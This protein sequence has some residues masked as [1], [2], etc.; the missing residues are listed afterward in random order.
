MKILSLNLGHGS[1]ACLFDNENL[2]YF[3]QEERLN[4]HKNYSG[5]PQ[6]CLEE[7][8]KITTDIDLLVITDYN[9]DK[10]HCITAFNFVKNF[11]FNVQEWFAQ[12]FP[13]HLTHACKS[14][15]SSPFDESIVVVWDGRGS[16]FNLTDGSVAYETTSVFHMS[17]DTGIKLLHK[18]LWRS[19]KYKDNR[20]KL[21][22]AQFG[23]DVTYKIDKNFTY[24]IISG[25]HDIGHYYGCVAEHFGYRVLDCGK[26]MGLHSYGSPNIKLSKL[27]YSEK[28]FKSD[29]ISK[30]N[31][32]Q[33]DVDKYPFL[34]HEDISKDLA[35]EVQKGLEKVGL[36]FLKKIF[37][38]YHSNNLVL[39]G[40]VSLNIVANSLYVK[41]LNKNI[42]ADPLCADEGTCIGA[43]QLALLQKTG[44]RSKLPNTLYFC[45]K[46]PEYEYT[47]F[48]GEELLDANYQTVVD[49]L[50]DKN[51]VAIFQGK[52]EAGPRAL[53]NRSILFDP[54]VVD[55][56]DIVNKIK[57]RESY[58]PFACTILLEYINDWFDT[59]C[60]KDSPD[61]MYSFD[62]LPNVKNVIPSVIHVDNTCRVQTITQKQNI[63]YY[64]LIHQ[65]YNKTKVPILFNT[66]F[67]LAGDP[68]VEKI[69]DALYTLRNSKLEY[70]YLP[71]LSKLIYIKNND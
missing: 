54:R 59:S 57:G 68:I 4:R 22:L 6:N 63:H 32:R 31:P 35:Y 12:S 48:E 30:D 69:N 24:E 47:L 15:F 62:A 25:T 45:G 71:E 3:N 8:K 19:N 64:N 40:G 11:G 39:S 61:M 14:F 50:L 55:G 43:A 7:I 17:Y 27:M 33:F 34:S 70:L 58:R 66:S 56:K 23:Q 18:K 21:N 36:N 16:N 10:D 2:I 49:L 51:V 1:S 41:E 67:N 44:R 65:F 5:Y 60:I 42:Y 28:G 46:N 37:K 20:P 9:Y 13:H 53:G 38:K 52:S 26:V 29:L